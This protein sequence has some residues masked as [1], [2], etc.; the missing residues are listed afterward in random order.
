MPALLGAGLLAAP[1][2]AQAIDFNVPLGGDDSIHGVL[3]TTAT[4]GVGLRTQGQ[5]VD[6][7]GKADL[8]PTACSTGRGSAGLIL[9][10]Q[11]Q[12]VYRTQSYP[13]QRLADVP[14]AY[15]MAHD[16]GDL[17]YNKG[18]IFQAPVKVTPDLT[19]TWKDFGF[20]GRL[21][22]FYDFVNDDFNDRH[23]DII[24]PQNQKS[25]GRI[26]SPVPG[27]SNLILPASPLYGNIP[28]LSQKLYGVGA[29]E[30]TK[31]TDPAVLKQV[32]TN[33]QY[34]D[35]YVYGKLPIPFT[36]D[37]KLTVKLGRQVVNW[38]EST[39]LVFNSINQANP[40]NGNN[41]Y[42]IGNQLEEDFTP[43]NMVFLSFEPLPNTTMEGFYQLEWKPLEAPAPGSYFSSNDVGTYNAIRSANL[44]FGSTNDD[45]NGI[46]T[47]LDSPLG[48]VTY[49][50]AYAGRSPD[51]NPR[52]AGQYGVKLDYYA[53]WLNNGT[54]MAVY[55]EHYH[56]RLP[57]LGFFAVQD[58]CARREGNPRH[59]DAT[60][61]VSFLLDCPGI[62]A[63]HG[64]LS[65]KKSDAVPLST[66]Y[67]FL[68]YPENIDLL[69]TSFS[70]TVGDYSVQGEVAYRPNL[71]MQVSIGDL[72]F[73]A[74][75]PAL[76]RCNEA[77]IHCLGT[78]GLNIA[79][80]ANGS[81]G[82][83]GS[84]DYVIDSKGTPGAY[85]DTF[86]LLGL[87]AAPGSAR[88]FPNFVIPYRGGIVG[89][90]PSTDLSKPLNQSNP[91]YIRGY[92]RYQLV[93]LDL[94]VTR[95][96][97]ASDNPFGA[98]QIIVLGEVG[99]D[100]VPDLPAHDALQINGPNTPLSATAGADGTG[101]DRSR[102]ACSNIPDCSYGPDGLRFNPHQQPI[103]D[104]VKSFAW[105]YRFVVLGS[106]ENVLPNIGIHP[107][108][109]FA[110]DVQ[111][112][113]PGPAFEFV[114][115]RKEVDT[116]YEFRYKASLSL[117]LGYTWYWGGGD[118]NV[119]SD[120][121]FAQAFV[122]YQ[123]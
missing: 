35:S 117:N 93:K 110:H 100:I 60:D 67:L 87:G 24:T 19:L 123:F 51:L 38:G 23:P 4:A 8:N 29:Y 82:S 112:I 116:L 72:E 32:G 5:N 103:G 18:S 1:P 75:G 45:P 15:T 78:G 30:R 56:S 57:Y 101:A 71:P 119:L 43:L 49:L 115:G 54:D 108:I 58:S 95:V 6:L 36:D 105:G 17:N 94:G 41:F 76:T 88:S 68:E 37:K 97:G 20:F 89:E 86:N 11:C 102:L 44:S 53:D 2:A 13:A 28:L 31:R 7:I 61:P 107:T 14:G 81:I 25:V 9:Y 84:S 120:R 21:L 104:F 114:G 42:R 121:D 118:Q 83:A 12:G 63:L 39:T 111:G 92:E 113:S 66:G 73:A 74:A 26:G 70:T 96:L 27:L 33:L 91:G 122:K 77:S 90:N 69:G 99:S 52:T 22:Y 62:P 85:N 98:D 106:Y 3:N 47:P 34:L 59:N 64:L 55:Y 50:T 10:Q 65:K 16:D 48:Q 79:N 46:G 80:M 40:I 109:L